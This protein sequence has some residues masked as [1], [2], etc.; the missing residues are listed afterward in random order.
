MEWNLINKLFDDVR[1][2]NE[3]LLFITLSY[4]ILEDI[5]ILRG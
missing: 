4:D 1:I 5:Y 2:C 3:T